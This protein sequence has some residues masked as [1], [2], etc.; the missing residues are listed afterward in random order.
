MN[1]HIPDS[2]PLTPRQLELL[3]AIKAE[4]EKIKTLPPWDPK[5]GTWVPE[6]YEIQ[7][8][9]DDLSVK[10]LRSGLLRSLPAESRRPGFLLVFDSHGES[11]KVLPGAG[12]FYPELP[13]WAENHFVEWIQMQRLREKGRET[14]RET[15]IPGLETGMK[16]P[17][18]MTLLRRV[19]ELRGYVVTDEMLINAREQR[20]IKEK[21]KTRTRK[22]DRPW[23]R[24]IKKLVEEGLVKKVKTPSGEKNP[25]SQAFKKMLKNR[26]PLWP[27]D[28]I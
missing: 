1:N 18:N 23:H 19:L 6:F 25:S 4:K 2:P 28:E 26:Y 3:E 24:V 5:T 16:R 10:A 22:E 12:V 7:T 13:P 8:K 9:I 21:K 11:A 20:E 27:W 17:K 14:L 15:K